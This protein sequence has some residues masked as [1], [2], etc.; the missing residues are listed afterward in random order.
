MPEWL[1]KAT[2][3][4]I[5]L[6][7]VCS[8]SLAW[9]LRMETGSWWKNSGA[10]TEHSCYKV[11]PKSSGMSLPSWRLICFLLC[12]RGSLQPPSPGRQTRRAAQIKGWLDS[13]SLVF[14]S[15]SHPF[16]SKPLP[17]PFPPTRSPTTTLPGLPSSFPVLP[18]P[19]SSWINACLLQLTDGSCCE[20]P[21]RARMAFSALSTP[22]QLHAEL[23][24]RPR[25]QIVEGN[26]LICHW[27]E[28]K[29]RKL[30][31]AIFY[32]LQTGMLLLWWEL[33]LGFQKYNVWV[34]Q[35]GDSIFRVSVF[36]L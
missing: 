10:K 35:R 22:D 19:P 1:W 18:H 12:P 8:N 11:N 36:L 7:Y 28:G 15:L 32:I 4:F 14:L 24:F 33:M 27:E 25:L 29:S 23:V 31:L 34:E 26:D 2:N 3:Y 13:K 17:P 16:K 21:H 5:F 9:A 30:K 6:E 20:S